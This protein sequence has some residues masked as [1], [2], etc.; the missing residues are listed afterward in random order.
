MMYTE[1]TNTFK[2]QDLSVLSNHLMGAGK[3]ILRMEWVP[4][5]HKLLY[6]L[7]EDGALLTLTYER[8]Q[9]VFGWAQHWTK[10]LFKDCCAVND[11]AGDVLYVTVQRKINGSWVKFVERIKSRAQ[12]IAEDFWCVDCGLSS[13]MLSP[14]ATLTPS[15]IAGTGISIVASAAVFSAGNVGDIIYLGG[16]KVEVI[17]YVSPTEVTVNFLRDITELLPETTNVPKIVAPGA[18]EIATPITV[19]SGLWHLEGETV[20]VLADGDAFLDMVVTHGKVTLVN[21]ATKIK[22]GLQYVCR[23]QTLPVALRDVQSDGNR[24]NILGLAVRLLDSRGLAFGDSFSNLVEMKD[25][26]D[27]DWGEEIALRSD[28]SYVTVNTAWTTEGEIF[29][30]QRYP[31]PGTVLG[32]V[33]DVDMGDE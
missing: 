30:E 26:T 11:P 23:G 13:T 12:T 14:A 27:E 8:E 7:R 3:E 24:K 15:A 6:C 21:P 31:L 9:E 1:Y 20:S 28:S 33:Y 17:T 22:V 16:G 18:W 5:P 32:F 25:R 2:I 4:E 10:G 19:V 29:F